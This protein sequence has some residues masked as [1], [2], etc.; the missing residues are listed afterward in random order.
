MDT[1]C[2]GAGLAAVIIRDKSQCGGNVEGL[3]HTHEGAPED[4]FLQRGGLAGHV[5]HSG[6]HHQRTENDELAA[7]TVSQETAH[8]AQRGI[9]DE[10]GRGHHAEFGLAHLDA[11]RTFRDGLVEHGQQLTIKVIE[12]YHDPEHSHANPRPLPGTS[13]GSGLEHGFVLKAIL[14]ADDNGRNGNGYGTP[15]SNADGF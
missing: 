7:E 8:G 6:P 11:V 1:G 4:E 2:H 3:A 13:G 9:N 14:Q 12:H 10:E 5:G 15:K